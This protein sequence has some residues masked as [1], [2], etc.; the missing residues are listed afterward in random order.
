MIMMSK[1]SPPRPFRRFLRDEQGAVVTEF[2]I[3]LPLLLWAWFAMYAFWDAY[4]TM[5]HAQKAAFAIADLLSR[6]QVAVTDNYRNG[7]RNVFAYMTN[8]GTGEVKTRFTSILRHKE[9]NRYQVHWSYSPGNAMPKL[10][11]NALQDQSMQGRLPVMAD[12]DYV[13]LVETSIHYTP[14]VDISIF[15]PTFTARDIGNFVL[16]RPRFM[17]VCESGQTCS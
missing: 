17:R 4:R 15:G 7:L 11:T 12:G 14:P 9:N 16:T 2:M 5:N 10:T 6:E 3:Y 1:K 13:L 8:R